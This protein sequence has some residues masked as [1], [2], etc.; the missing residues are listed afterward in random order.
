MDNRLEKALEFS[1]YVTTLSNQKR[2]LQEQYKQNLIYFFNGC[3][4][5]IDKELINYTYMLIQTDNINNVVFIDDNEIPIVIEDVTKFLE[6]IKNIF[7]E[8]SKNYY[9]SYSKLK[10]NR[11]IA[12]LVDYD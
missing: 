3:Q 11:T 2:V 10:N 1:N 6:D 5:T 9:N 12:K 8:E 7:L 4:F